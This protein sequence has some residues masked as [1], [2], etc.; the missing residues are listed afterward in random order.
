MK[1]L[2]GLL[3]LF[4]LFIALTP[5]IAL[6]A[7]D[8]SAQSPGSLPPASGGS[9]A[10]PDGAQAAE[11][12][13]TGEE[14][15]LLDEAN[16]QTLRLS[17][18]EYLIGA[19]MSEMPALYEPEALKAQAVAAHTYALYVKELREANPV[20]E[21]Q[22]AYFTVNTELCAGYMTPE[23]ARSRFGADY[24][25]YSQK[26]TDAVDAVLGQA[27]QCD[28]RLISACYHAIS[29]GK[30]EYSE[31]VFSAPAPYLVSVD[32][33]WDTGAEGYESVVTFAPSEL[34]DLLRLGKQD[35]AAAGD[36]AEWLGERRA[37]DAGTVLTQVICGTSFTGVE[38]REM[39]GLRSAA[40]TLSYA[41]GMF[42][43][44]VHGYG[45]GVGMSQ[46]GAN[47]MAK[48]GK[49]YAEIL[50]HYYP[51]TELVQLG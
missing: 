46:Y 49:T 17:E 42:T 37:T 12:A 50:A 26:I 27:L 33:G 32:S 3:L 19:V 9:A 7:P 1:Q 21:L 39:L 44:T 5:A 8:R 25:L 28:G 40:F 20:P 15:I 35:F 48:E 34:D 29:P 41:D 36:P 2:I 45:H 10:Q 38:L 24:A 16:G 23:R 31:N 43:C 47:A 14:L 11:P 6:L 18:R 30:T 4:A 13:Y 22:G 51:N